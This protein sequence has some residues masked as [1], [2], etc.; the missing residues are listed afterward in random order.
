MSAF[1][2]K[3]SGS[4]MSRDEDVAYGNAILAGKSREAALE[5]AEEARRAQQE[6]FDRGVHEAKEIV[7]IPGNNTQPV[8]MH[9]AGGG[10]Q[11]C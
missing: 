9:G 4:I 8:Y 7:K 6:K 11:G 1:G 2:K 3:L 5:E 10:F